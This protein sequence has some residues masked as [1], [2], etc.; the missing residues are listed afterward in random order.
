LDTDD[1]LRVD[2]Q[3][4]NFVFHINDQLIGE[5]TDPDYASGEIGLYVESF[6][7]PNTHIH[8]DNL[9]VRNFEV[10][11][12]CNVAANT[13]NVRSGPGKEFSSSGY[14]RT[15]DTVEPVGR[16]EDSLWL[17]VKLAGSDE[18]GW[19]SN[20]SGYLSCTPDVKLL[21]VVTP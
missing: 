11:V 1:I 4:Q 2:A 7:S 20:S 13:I 5:V 6:D 17:K 15:G 19:L 21:P 10:A 18:Q 16:T 3:G 9:A 12:L 8:F 14:I